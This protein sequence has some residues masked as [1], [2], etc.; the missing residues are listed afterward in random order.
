M[1]A[2]AARHAGRATASVRGCRGRRRWCLAMRS[3][4]SGLSSGGAG[5]LESRR[6]LANILPTGS[7]GFPARVST[8]RGREPATPGVFGTLGE[9]C[10]PAPAGCGCTAMLSKLRE[11]FGLRCRGR[12][13]VSADGAL[14]ALSGG[15]ARAAEVLHR[16]ATGAGVLAATPARRSASME[17]R[18]LDRDEILATDWPRSCATSS[19]VAWRTVRS[20][21]R[22]SPRA[23]WSDSSGTL[24]GPTRRTRSARASVR[25]PRAGPPGTSTSSSNP[26]TGSAGRS[27]GSGTRP[28]RGSM[29]AA[30]GGA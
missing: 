19:S 20:A 26:S 27:C 5:A 4:C 6:P 18:V 25:C 22:Y 28:T 3:W 8:L 29:P 9:R 13:G 10:R 23:G 21:S 2:S 1:P 7:S 11:V 17:V 24:T 16:G 30:C 12:A 14:Q 15:W